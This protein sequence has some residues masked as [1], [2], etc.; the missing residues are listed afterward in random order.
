MDIRK[1]LKP[2]KD[3]VVEID[4]VEYLIDDKA[5]ASMERGDEKVDLI[6]LYDS[7]RYPFDIATIEKS[8]LKNGI[9]DYLD[10][11]DQEN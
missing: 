7:R 6:Q 9:I 8:L 5:V 3:I 10:K 4:E 1:L 2:G 11:K